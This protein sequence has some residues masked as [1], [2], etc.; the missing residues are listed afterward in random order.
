MKNHALIHEYWVIDCA[1]F[2]HIRLLGAAGLLAVDICICFHDNESYIF[3]KLFPSLA[4]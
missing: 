1:Y 4:V 3:A 2:S